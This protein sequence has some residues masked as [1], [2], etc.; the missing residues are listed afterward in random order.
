MGNK[1]LNNVGLK[2]L[3]RQGISEP[4]FSVDCPD[5]HLSSVRVATVREKDLEN[6]KCSRS[7][8]SPGIS[9]SVREI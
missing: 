7:G 9:F 2:I 6:E 4:V 3:L 1:S 8:K 5:I